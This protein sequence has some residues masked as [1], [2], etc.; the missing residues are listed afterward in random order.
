MW[1]VSTLRWVTAQFKP[2]TVS[3][4][5]QCAEK[6][7]DF[8][9]GTGELSAWVMR[10]HLIRRDENRARDCSARC[11]SWANRGRDSQPIPKAGIGDSPRF[12]E[13]TLTRHFRESRVV[14][15]P[16]IRGD[17]NRAGLF[18]E[19]SVVGKA[20]PIGATPVM[21]CNERAWT[22]RRPISANL[23]IDLF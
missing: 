4:I 19:V 2:I 1:F 18:G 3:L 6:H 21:E 12:A 17:E 8:A 10:K 15:N 11:R 23:S 14:R 13:H 5:C 16:L 7:T 20:F 9:Y 22:G